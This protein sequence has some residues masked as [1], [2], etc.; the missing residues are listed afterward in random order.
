MID[1]GVDG[2]YSTV[3]TGHFP[4]N[5]RVI[6]EQ[7]G[8]TPAKDGE[9]CRPRGGVDGLPLHLALGQH[10]G[11]VTHDTSRVEGSS[12]LLPGNPRPMTD[13]TPFR[14]PADPEPYPQP[15]PPTATRAGALPPAR[16]ADPATRAGAVP[17]ARPADPGT[18]PDSPTADAGAV[19]SDPRSDARTGAAASP[20]P[21]RRS[22]GLS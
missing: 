7:H 14:G 8:Y 21:N 2:F 1:Q 12:A 22:L 16:P 11:R 15:A 20:S 5:A 19:T 10:H 3:F 17:P 9:D 4:A 13:P 18:D 6:L